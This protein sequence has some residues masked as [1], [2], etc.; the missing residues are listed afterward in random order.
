MQSQI[1]MVVKLIIKKMQIIKFAYK[2][3]IKN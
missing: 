1:Q 2:R 3:L